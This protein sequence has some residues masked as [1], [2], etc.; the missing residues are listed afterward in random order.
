MKE[1]SVNRILG[2]SPEENEDL[3]ERFKK[4]FQYFGEGK[5]YLSERN[6]TPDETAIINLANQETNNVIERFGVP[7]MD[8]PLGNIHVFSKKEYADFTSE[9][10]ED[11]DP[12]QTDAIFSTGTQIIAMEDQGENLVEFTKRVLHEMYHLKSYQSVDFARKSEKRHKMRRMGMAIALRG[13][14]AD[15]IVFAFKN[16]NEALTESLSMLSLAG[17]T[18]RS[19]LPGALSK[20]LEQGHGKF[21]YVKEMDK[22]SQLIELIY[23]KNKEKFGNKWE[24]YKVF[25]KAA[26]SGKLLEAARL[27]EKTF[28]KG[29]FRKLGEELQK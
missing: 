6:K 2:G 16:L 23:D 1:S 18:A 17:M 11:T 27:I 3:G 8:V 7:P 28:G 22:M 14:S 21:S 26:F 9:V 15:R 13:D 5:I 25:F 4:A 10:A 24:V 12:S 29:S 19:D 20:Q